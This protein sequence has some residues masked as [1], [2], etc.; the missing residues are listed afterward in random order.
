[1]LVSFYNYYIF[2]TFFNFPFILIISD[3]KYLLHC[4]MLFLIF[5]QSKYF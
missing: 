2:W 4:Y 3:S 1:V 5:V